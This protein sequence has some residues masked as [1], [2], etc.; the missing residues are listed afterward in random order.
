MAKAR[1]KAAK[2][3]PAKSKSATKGSTKGTTNTRARSRKRKKAT[4]PRDWRDR[5]LEAFSRT[6]CV[7]AACEETGIARWTVYKRR[8]EEPDFGDEWDDIKATRI[9]ESLKG[10]MI[11]QAIE[12]V[13]GRPVIYT[14]V[15]EVKDEDGKVIRST[16]KT[17]VVQVQEFDGANQRFLLAKLSPDEFGKRADGDN[18]SLKDRAAMACAMIEAMK[19]SIPAMPSEEASGG[20]N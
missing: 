14:E 4:S 9:M 20:D 16:K 8:D 2:K 7:S 3:A 10:T 1:K 13:P 11:R 19:G 12:G 6:R 17:K 18:E 5:W 15:E